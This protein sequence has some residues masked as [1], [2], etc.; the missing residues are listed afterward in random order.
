MKP[1]VIIALAACL[2]STA[3]AF[4]QDKKSEESIKIV[5][6]KNETLVDDKNSTSTATTSETI[7]STPA[8]TSSNVNVTTPTPLAPFAPEARSDIGLRPKPRANLKGKRLT[9]PLSKAQRKKLQVK[10]VRPQKRV[11]TPKRQKPL[12]KAP[13]PKVEA[14]QRRDSPGYGPPA[15]VTPQR[16]VIIKQAGPSKE[17]GWVGHG[18]GYNAP[19]NLENPFPSTLPKWILQNNKIFEAG[20]LY[21]GPPESAESSYN[22]PPPPPPTYNAPAAPAAPEVAEVSY[23]APTSYN[24]PVIPVSSSYNSVSVPAELPTYSADPSPVYNPPA[25]A[26]ASSYEAAQPVYNSAPVVPTYDAA[27]QAPASYDSVAIAPTYN[28]VQQA[29]PSYVPVD[30]YGAAVVSASYNSADSSQPAYNQVDA[31]PATYGVEAFPPPFYGAPSTSY[32]AAEPASTYEAAAP[33]ASY[34]AVAPATTYGAAAPPSSYEAVAP[35]TT[36]GAAAP[37][38]S[39]EAAAPPPLIYEVAAPASYYGASAPVPTY[40][41][42]APPTTYEAAAPVASYEAAAPAATYEAAAPVASYEAAGPVATYEAAAPP[43]ASYGTVVQVPSAYDSPEAPEL[44]TYNQLVP[45]EYNAP[46]QDYNAPVATGYEAATEAAPAAPVYSKY[47]AA[48]DPQ[49]D[50]KAE[51]IPINYNVPAPNDQS[52]YNLFNA[53]SD[54]TEYQAS[55]DNSYSVPSIYEV[56]KP[57]NFPSYNAIPAATEEYS[58]PPPAYGAPQEVYEVPIKVEETY[59]AAAAPEKSP[60]VFYIFYENGN[61]EQA[62]AAQV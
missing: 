45:A 13:A 39:Y 19:H 43:P 14:P 42:A 55:A 10:P 20:L 38:S 22:P 25:Q 16:E 34:E 18:N 59:K 17:F 50:Y 62:V 48:V 33:P 7:S 11:Q 1:L 51:T 3:S 52:L 8:T 27:V 44:A 31:V 9:K 56:G 2:L 54:Q 40:Q 35:A 24:V 28:V 60:E 41:T 61:Q 36:Y 29:A 23:S 6:V 12:A 32:K 15:Q 58:Q 49:A 4:P 57:G 37:P 5:D 47:G 21:P 30:S 26:P 53:P 46:A